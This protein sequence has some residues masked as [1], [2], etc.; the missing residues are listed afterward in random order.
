MI[1]NLKIKVKGAALIFTVLL[2]A[3]FSLMALM[4]STMLSLHLGQSRN[5]LQ[6]SL[7]ESGEQAVLAHALAL[8]DHDVSNSRLFDRVFSSGWK[9]GGE[10]ELS[11]RFCIKDQ[12]SDK[13][14]SSAS[15]LTAMREKTGL[16]KVNLSTMDSEDPNNAFLRES[17]IKV[18]Q[19]E[20][21]VA[22][23]VDEI[24]DRMLDQ[25]DVNR[26]SRENDRNG[27]S[28]VITGITKGDNR[29]FTPIDITTLSS[30]FDLNRKTLDPCKYFIVN[31]VNFEAQN[32]VTNLYVSLM[33]RP[34]G[35]KEKAEWD[36]F[37]YFAGGRIG[38]LWKDWNWEGKDVSFLSPCGGK[39]IKA[40]ILEARDNGFLLDGTPEVSFGSTIIRD[41]CNRRDEPGSFK[42]EAKLSDLWVITGLQTNFYYSCK[43]RQVDGHK[44]RPVFVPDGILQTGDFYRVQTGKKG[45]LVFSFTKTSRDA[46]FM[47]V[48][49]RSPEYY[50]FENT[51]SSSLNLRDWELYC[52]TPEGLSS[53]I[54][55]QWVKHPVLKPGDK[56]D[57]LS[58]ER[59][60][61]G[62]TTVNGFAPQADWAIPAKI[63]SHK[64][65]SS[66][67]GYYA[68]IILETNPNYERQNHH[69]R[70]G[71]VYIGNRKRK[72]MM[73]FPIS[74]QNGSS[75]TVFLGPKEYAR[76]W[77]R[78]LGDSVY[79]GDFQIEML[80]NKSYVCDQWG[81]K[82]TL[83]SVPDNVPW[84]IGYHK[85]KNR[86]TNREDLE[87]CL[88]RFSNRKAVLPFSGKISHLT[89]TKCLAIPSGGNKLL[90]HEK[91]AFKENFWKDCD[92]VTPDGEVFRITG[93]KGATVTL[94]RN[95]KLKKET[96][97]LIT[98]DGLDSFL[99]G[100][101][102]P[103]RVWTLKLTKDALLPGDL[104]LPGHSPLPNLP[105]P[106][107]TI[108]V[109]N[110]LSDKWEIRAE[111]AVFPE[112]DVIHLGRITK[113]HRLSKGEIKIKIVGK[114]AGPN[115]YWLRQPFLI[116]DN[117]LRKEKEERCDSFAV[118]YEI[119]A[120][121]KR[122][123]DKEPT[124]RKGSFLIQRQWQRGGIRPRSFFAAK[125]S[126]CKPF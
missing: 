45:E 88:K 119:Q 126:Y 75:L 32:G 71:F 96:T 53:K 28:L 73:P 21:R 68:S 46:L 79:F 31:G 54:K 95:H 57:L 61:K 104:Y 22:E 11:Y 49:M 35:D 87:R 124:T 37:T 82:T 56:L 12:W 98:P 111:N 39:Y 40:K 65:L 6:D 77:Y 4:F 76:H 105:S 120:L 114:G 63:K 58:W 125:S 112:G 7:V 121:D 2:L 33:D 70:H 115:G 3:F 85:I 92:L 117:M 64:L 13:T 18:L 26:N 101:I 74:N 99:A 36:R 9:T 102:L 81:Q 15:S 23:Q 78:M 48:E 91:P 86:E 67:L 123:K 51:S 97:I 84:L 110:S 25:F 94:D 100:P 118:Y 106:E 69:I 62:K 30:F 122:E 41:W 60:E 83:L 93:S 80:R 89:E 50:H 72:N 14:F 5:Y 116:S 103:E 34:Y 66:E 10:S 47:G 43:L 59:G 29:I 27:E 55:P 42:L 8:C 90:L 16:E 107:Y 1:L 44:A 24:V 20:E 19:E 109:Y 17:C 113:D 108:S 38:N 52:E